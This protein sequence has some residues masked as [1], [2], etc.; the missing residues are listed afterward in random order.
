MDLPVTRF[1]LAQIVDV[2]RV[3]RVLVNEYFSAKPERG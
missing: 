1:D 3:A 2:D